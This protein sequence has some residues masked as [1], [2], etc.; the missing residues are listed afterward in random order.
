MPPAPPPSPPPRYHRPH[1]H[2]GT[3]VNR[4][5]INSI[6]GIGPK[7]FEQCSGFIRI[8]QPDKDSTIRYKVMIFGD[9]AGVITLLQMQYNQFKNKLENRTFYFLMIFFIIS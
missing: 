9:L 3:I 6:P 4:L 8:V 5:E 1:P 2:P 7:T